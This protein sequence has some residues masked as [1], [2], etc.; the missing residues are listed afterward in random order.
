VSLRDFDGTDL[1]GFD[2]S[3]I[4]PEKD[5]VGS[6]VPVTV[7]EIYTVYY[8]YMC[9]LQSFCLYLKIVPVPVI[10]FLNIYF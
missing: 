4:L 7:T 10:I 2:V 8:T 9:L 6:A 1:F 5:R 3:C